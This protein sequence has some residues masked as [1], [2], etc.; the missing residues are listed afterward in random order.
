MRNL[1]ENERDIK[2][3]KKKTLKLPLPHSL[4]PRRPGSVLKSSARMSLY[5][6]LMKS[7]HVFYWLWLRS[8]ISFNLKGS[9]TCDKLAA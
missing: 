7:V 3:K 9:F 4:K 5:L 2:K 1:K 6:S 8:R